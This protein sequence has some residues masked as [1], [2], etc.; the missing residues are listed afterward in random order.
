M[1]HDSNKERFNARKFIDA[2]T[3]ARLSNALDQQALFLT[4]NTRLASL[5]RQ[6]L[7]AI[8][9]Q[10]LE[11][12]QA[13]GSA[14]WN[15]PS[16]LPFETWTMSCWQ[17]AMLAGDLP[18]QIL[19]SPAQDTLYWERV[20]EQSETAAALLSPGS[21]A[22]MAQQGYQLLRQSLV[23]IDQ[24]AFEFNSE[25]DSRAFYQWVQG[26]RSLLAD[27]EYIALVDAQQKLLALPDDSYLMQQRLSADRD[28]PIIMLGF[29]APTALQTELV[30]RLS[31]VAN[32]GAA[33]SDSTPGHI[34]LSRACEQLYVTDYPDFA[35]EIEAAAHWSRVHI[36]AQPDARIAVVVQNLAQNRMLVER[37]FS[38]VF[39]PASAVLSEPVAQPDF[40]ISAGIPLAQAG[41]IRVALSLIDALCQ[42]LALEQWL[43]LLQSPY[44]GHSQ[45]ELGVRA[46]LIEKACE[47]GEQAYTLAELARLLQWRNAQNAGTDIQSQTDT[48]TTTDADGRRGLLTGLTQ[49]AQIYL[50]ANARPA[51][52]KQ[53][54]PSQWLPT[55]RKLL[56]AFLW[57]GIRT[58]NSDEYQQLQRF[59]AC[60]QDFATLDSI[61]GNVTLAKACGLFK[62]HCQAQVYHSETVK[63]AGG[64]QHVQVLGALEASGQTFDYLWLIGMSERHWPAPVQAHPLIPHVLQKQY[65][66]PQASVDRE[67]YYAQR[68][69]RCYLSSAVHVVV[70]YPAAVDDIACQVSPLFAALA[71][72]WEQQSGG[73]VQSAQAGLKGNDVALEQSPLTAALYYNYNNEK[74]NDN[75]NTIF[76]NFFD[77]CGTALAPLTTHHDAGSENTLPGGLSMVKD[78]NLNPLVAYFK[79]RLGVRPLGEVILGVSALE[80]GNS[81][82]EALEIIWQALGGLAALQDCTAAQVSEL[83]EQAVEQSVNHIL[84][85]RFV[86]LPEKIQALEKQ[87]LANTL[88]H[89]LL[90]ESKR[91]NFIVDSIER[92][93]TL[94]VKQ[95][96]LRLRIDRI[97]KLDDGQLLLI[98][99]KS[100]ATS[101]TGWF[102]ERVTEPQLP[103][104]ALALNSVGDVNNDKPTQS[105]KDQAMAI[106]YAR[107]KAG[108]LAFEGLS[109]ASSAA[110]DIKGIQTVSDKSNCDFDDWSA[111]RAHWQRQVTKAVGDIAAGRA[112]VDLRYCGSI[113]AQYRA[114][115]RWQMTE[116]CE[117]PLAAEDEA[118]A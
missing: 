32:S 7:D 77:H 91:P 43:S 63:K 75:D 73:L 60:C 90:L 107:V 74:D 2:E 1:P 69:S 101:Q 67:F 51:K 66:M 98:D 10:R 12:Q 41:V 19:L 115:A 24:Y 99:Y 92:S 114:A 21:A 118:S 96:Q 13:T 31:P 104:Y 3:E 49:A 52:N 9:V 4:P 87:R 112:M 105:G 58:Q 39:E 100:G 68:L 80:R 88:Y 50:A 71:T 81:L 45:G 59:E 79:W 70:S 29:T 85:R 84:K 22:A 37:K 62:R 28:R 111:L 86:P 11:A 48:N 30:K 106:S 17:S 64:A 54:L 46:L 109:Q 33:S 55:M 15:S 34:F 56:E 38:Q 110:L 47:A 23:D 65:D 27:S 102:N 40:N 93:I 8:M 94:L 97:D 57:P 83:V 108:D 61:A 6:I 14:V 116:L 26:Y 82:H 95:W 53:Q 16:V 103:I 20:L 76:E 117:D 36:Q 72:E 78:Y 35:A 25:V 5:V 44:L 89:W 42:P 113:D 18:A